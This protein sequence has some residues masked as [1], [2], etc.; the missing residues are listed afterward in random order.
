[1][2]YVSEGQKRCWRE[3]LTKNPVRA[4]SSENK[5]IF[6]LAG[7]ASEVVL[8][9]EAILW[10]KIWIFTGPVKS[11]STGSTAERLGSER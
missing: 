8:T 3:S 1:M 10:R 5:R 6:Q 7:C 9:S 11:R 2:A 4:Q